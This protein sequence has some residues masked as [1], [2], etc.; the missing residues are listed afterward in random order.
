MELDRE[1]YGYLIL[2]EVPESRAAIV[3]SYCRTITKV[4]RF[5]QG[6]LQKQKLLLMEERATIARELHDSLA[7][8]LSYLKIQTSLLQRQLK[9]SPVTTSKAWK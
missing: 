6:L 1:R 5:E 8:T 4:L 3:N 7:Q 2:P 9:Q